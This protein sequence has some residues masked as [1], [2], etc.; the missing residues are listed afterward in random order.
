MVQEVFSN[1]LEAIHD[2]WRHLLG[3][4]PTTLIFAAAAV[5]LVAYF[6]LRNR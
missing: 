2:S 5:A 6:L 3:A 1:I 4:S